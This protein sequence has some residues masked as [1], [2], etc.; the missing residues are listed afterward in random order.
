MT[1]SNNTTIASNI[2]HQMQVAALGT[3]E[4]SGFPHVSLVTVVPRNDGSALLL[5]S[6]LARHTENIKRDGR[7]S[8]LVSAVPMREEVP[9]EKLGNHDPQKGPPEDPLADERITVHGHIEELPADQIEFGKITFLDRH[10]TASLYIGFQD[11]AL[12]RFCPSK[13]FL[14]GGF[15]RIETLPSKILQ[16]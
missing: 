14:V 4:K 12:Y 2:W 8:L 9:A 15:G 16:M 10:P 3:L 1:S 7:A 11:F 5:L 6:G 13:I